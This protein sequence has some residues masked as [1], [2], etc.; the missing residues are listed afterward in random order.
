MSYILGTMSWGSWGKKWNTQEM[1]NFLIHAHHQGFNTFDMADIYG[2]HTTEDNFGLAWKQSRIRRD[3][4]VF[5][6]KTGIVMENMSA[7]GQTKHYNHSA[8]YIIES[9]EKSLKKLQTDYIDTFLIHRP[10]P[11]MVYEEIA[12]AATD[13]LKSGK[14]KN[15][16]VS[17]FSA[18]QMDVLSD[19][20]NVHCNQVECSL[21]H[22]TPMINGDMDMMIKKKIIPM[23]W[24]PLGKIFDNDDD[25]SFRILDL[26]TQLA[27]QYECPPHII[28]Y[29]WLKKH[30]A[31][32]LPVVG[33]TQIERI[34]ELKKYEHIEVTNI[35]WYALWTASRGRRVP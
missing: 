19:Y 16:G 5:I 12:E 7:N 9:C 26:V 18:S 31:N 8:K 13:L 11:L 4:L 30:P 29:S 32:I 2:N 21:K 15:F 28:L 20:I 27:L 24:A 17:N 23:A 10:G 35:D 25:I 1:S 14:I 34:A 22:F 6:T 33:T 3:Q